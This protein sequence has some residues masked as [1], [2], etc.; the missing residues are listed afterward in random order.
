MREYRLKWQHCQLV[1]EASESAWPK[2]FSPKTNYLVGAADT[3]SQ[4]MASKTAAT[5]KK[6][7]LGYRAQRIELLEK[8]AAIHRYINCYSES[9][10]PV[11]LIRCCMCL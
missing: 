1:V 6:T 2:Y 5:P 7:L 3:L 8:N 4:L 11:D 9:Y 10:R